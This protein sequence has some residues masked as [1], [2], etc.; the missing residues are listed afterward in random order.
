MPPPP[1][2]TATIAY[3]PHHHS[4]YLAYIYRTNSYFSTN[5]AGRVAER[6][7]AH[8]V[9]L[10]IASLSYTS[11]Y[12]GPW[13]AKGCLQESFSTGPVVPPWVVWEVPRSS[14]LW[15]SLFFCA[16]FGSVLHPPRRIR[17]IYRHYLCLPLSLCPLAPS[18]YCSLHAASLPR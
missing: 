14:H 13:L 9:E 1:F 8:T 17:Y 4:L 10:H 15:A 5:T 11:V 12:L 2:T 16:F 3:R 18:A 7:G 6:S